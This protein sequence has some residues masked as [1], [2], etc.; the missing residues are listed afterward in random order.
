[1]ETLGLLLTIDDKIVNVCS[2]TQLIDSYRLPVITS[3]LF[4]LFFGMAAFV[5]TRNALE[6]PVAYQSYANYALL[7]YHRFILGL[8]DRFTMPI[9]L[10]IGLAQ[11]LIAVSMFLK[12]D[13]F[14]IG[15]L[16]GMVFR[17]AIFP[18]GFGSVL[19][20]LLM[21][22]LAFIDSKIR[23]RFGRYASRDERYYP[24]FDGHAPHELR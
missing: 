20:S 23:N 2:V 19:P 8:F 21:V 24:L 11:A 15:R 14:R 6:T 7:F 17:I 1:M 5:N 9:V 10:S 16:G 3:V 13:W 22:A 18:V 12:G 4:F